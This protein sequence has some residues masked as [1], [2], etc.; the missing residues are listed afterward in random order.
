MEIAPR[1]IRRSAAVAPVRAELIT[2]DQG[3]QVTEIVRQ[4]AGLRIDP[5]KL[6]FLTLRLSRRLRA[7]SIDGFDAYMHLLSGEN[8]P[9]EVR[10]LV[11]ALTTH[12]TSFFREA[13]HYEWLAGDGLADLAARGAGID[14]TLVV[15]SAACS[16]GVELWS[17]AITLAEA[18]RRPA[19]IRRFS[20]FG[21]DISRRILRQAESATYSELE[22]E[23]VSRE[24]LTRYFMR[25]RATH[26][27]A[28]TTFYRVVPE[29][30]RYAR[31]AEAN[32]SALSGLK[33]LQADVIFLRN[34]LI[35]F[36]SQTQAR[37]VSDVAA[38]L[39][40]GGYLL[41]G[42]AESAPPELGLKAVG[43]SIYRRV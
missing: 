16:T 32:L 27:R 23:G 6:D 4:A 14:R 38:R 40:T 36:D 34:V 8:G 5:R 18:A 29:L 1:S 19:G 22:I 25:S 30:R 11:E 9:E 31:F 28:R 7:L 35:Y 41:T 37:I 17:A 33:D 3:R 15:W 12:T 43:P 26:T 13:K 42:H 20:L 2:A 39:R 10:H 21:T 24:Y